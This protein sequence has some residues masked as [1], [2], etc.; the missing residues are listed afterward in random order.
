MTTDT[1]KAEIAQPLKRTLVGR[2]VSNKMDKTV[3]VL[4]ERK[5]KHPV[6]GK[7]VV[8]STKFHVHDETDKLNEGDLVEITETRPM[9]KTKAWTVKRVVEA[10]AA[11]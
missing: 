11:V 3:T 2:V 5:V 1:S 8:R 7:Y 10:A 4:V 9:S 6:Y